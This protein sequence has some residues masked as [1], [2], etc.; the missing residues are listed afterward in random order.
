MFEWKRHDLS[1]NTLLPQAK[2]W[3][4]VLVSKWAS[5]SVTTTATCSMNITA[6]VSNSTVLPTSEFANYSTLSFHSP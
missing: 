3:L 5:P 4:F 1:H 6:Y 2:L